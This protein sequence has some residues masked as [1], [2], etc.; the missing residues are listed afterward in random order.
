MFDFDPREL[1]KRENWTPSAIMLVV[2]NAVAIFFALLQGMDPASVV[3]AYWLESVIIGGY[4]ILAFGAIGLK[5]ART[6]WR[7]ATGSWAMGAFFT[8]HY[9]MFHAGYFVF[10]F[11]LPWFTPD[12]AELP[13]V[14]L[15]AGIFLISHG[16]SFVSNFLDKPKR[17]ECTKDNL[18]D[19]MMAPYGR[20]LPMHLGIILSGF[21]V[22]PLLAIFATADEISG[23]SLGW[24]YAA[25]LAGLL[26][27]MVLKTG[28]DV[29]GHMIRYKK[30]PGA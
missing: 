26:V 14:L 11:I 27:F 17:L 28:A 16:Y 12:L 24:E 5:T 25:K 4:T 15:L 1:L 20:I 7:G 23:T 13:D 19:V 6:D 9:G 8:V 30:G 10:L 22:G 21:L 3:W 2:G 18:N 29:A